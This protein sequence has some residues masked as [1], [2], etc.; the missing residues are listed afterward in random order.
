MSPWYCCLTSNIPTA[1]TCWSQ[2]WIKGPARKYILAFIQ[3]RAGGQLAVHVR[4]PRYEKIEVSCKVQMYPGYDYNTYAVE[5]NTALQRLLTPWAFNTAQLPRFA[6]SIYKSV[7]INY[8]EDLPYVD[9]VTEVKMFHWV[10]GKRLTED[11]QMINATVP[12]A[13]LTTYA[14][15]QISPVPS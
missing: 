2:E 12:D 1:L 4:N 9:Y 11:K 15:H 5:L 3:E 7:L 13:I 14:T 8:I 6:G 10:A